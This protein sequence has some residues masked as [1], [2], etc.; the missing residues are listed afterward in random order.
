MPI[1]DA[2]FEIRFSAGVP[3]SSVL[4][5]LLFSKLEGSKQIIRLP[6][7]DIPEQMRL[8]DP[9]LQY[10]PILRIV[11]GTFNVNIGD[12]SCSV[13]CNLPYPGWTEF[14][15]AIL[16][17]NQFVGET[18]LLAA[19]ERMALKYTNIIPTSVGSSAD[20][21][22][23]DLR[24]GSKDAKNGLFHVRAEIIDGEYLH[25][26]QLAS[27]GAATLPDGTTLCE[28]T[29][30]DIDTMR[31]NFSNNQPTK[32][33]SMLPEALDALHLRTK[34]MFFSLLKPETIRMMGATYD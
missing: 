27:K 12:R 17:I 16:Q 28:G 18:N 21:A 19:I 13:G 24:L 1:V 15:R 5:G 20:I 22:D 26:T 14:K 7:A 29:V 32:F 11:W 23:Y 9:N 10:A 25:L 4:P 31:Q 6:T 34:A 2:V 30:I 8:M 33:F 3:I